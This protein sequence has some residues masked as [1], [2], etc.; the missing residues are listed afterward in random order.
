MDDH[1]FDDFRRSEDETPRQ[2][3][4]AFAAARTPASARTGKAHLVG[5]Q[6]GMFRQ[7]PEHAG[8]ES[9]GF[10]PVP[11]CQSLSSAPAAC[12]WEVDC[13]NHSNQV[14]RSTAYAAAQGMD[15]SL[16]R[17]K[18]TPGGWLRLAGFESSVIGSNHLFQAEPGR[19]MLSMCAW[20]CVPIPAR[21]G[22]FRLQSFF[23]WNVLD[24]RVAFVYYSVELNCVFRT[25]PRADPPGTGKCSPGS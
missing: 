16:L 24:G 22:G 5:V 20:A 17:C 12:F 14:Q 18:Y 4:G 23:S 13:P 3:D 6:L 7:A 19:G 8:E 1:I 25:G 21:R 11:G 2:A 10:S 15:G 9:S